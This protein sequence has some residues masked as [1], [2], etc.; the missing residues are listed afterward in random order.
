MGGQVTPEQPC[1]WGR[2]CQ[3]AGRWEGPELLSLSP[4]C[5]HPAET[6]EKSQNV[7]TACLIAQWG[8]SQPDSLHNPVEFKSKLCQLELSI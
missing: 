1:Y 7:P 4:C 5:C 8:L 3:S 2:G 6:W